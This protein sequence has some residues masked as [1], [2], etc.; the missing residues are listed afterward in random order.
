MF[1]S[2]ESKLYS[3]GQRL[4]S[5]L[6]LLATQPAIA[7]EIKF[8]DEWNNAKPFESIPGMTKLEA[9]RRFLPGG[10]II[11]QDKVF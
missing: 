8:Q 3:R 9:I 4:T 7:T 2:I 1:R 5:Q 11:L 6:R 10:D